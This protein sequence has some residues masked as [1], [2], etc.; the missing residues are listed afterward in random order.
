[1]RASASVI[2]DFD[3]ILNLVGPLDDATGVNTPRDRFRSYLATG[4]S[5]VG[6]VRDAVQTCITHSGPQYARALQDLVNYVGS[7]IGF[8][9]E[10]G[11]Y[12]GVT[13]K[14]GHDGLWRSSSSVLVVESK[15]TDAYTINSAT[16]PNYIN[17][18][19]SDGRITPDDRAIGLYVYA[20][21]DPG[22]KQLE[23]AI[24]AEKRTQE[25]RVASVNAVL[26]LAELI[27]Q[28]IISHGEALAILWP[29][30]VWIDET[31]NL[32]QRVTAG[33]QVEPPPPQAEPASAPVT[34]PATTAAARASTEPAPAPVAS[35]AATAAKASPSYYLTPV[36]DIP[37]ETARET[38]ERLVG[39]GLWAFSKGTPHRARVQPGDRM[40]FYQGGY[41]V[42]AT[43]DVASA[44]EDKPMPG[45]VKDPTK[46]SWTF[47]LANVRFFLDEPIVIDA[48]MR[49]Q[50]DAF[51]GRDPSKVWSWFV[52]A[53]RAVTA[54]D[55]AL[56]TG[57]QPE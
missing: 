24:I 25:L 2:G 12:Q 1:M 49:S 19:R 57:Q 28:D 13:N 10:Y 22:V 14:V 42:V 50:L 46:Y 32:L 53:N 54:H 3:T 27:Q 45:I 38:I 26:S 55:F 51:A 37:E 23:H 30:G 34:S 5:E 41:G 7:L 36:A 35:H 47:Q 17:L 4:L 48:A 39:A 44:P 6:L 18:L 29:S 52:F 33:S 15:T 16:L 21:V 31:V 20:K 9:V 40:A 56:L 43:A 11:R 8:E